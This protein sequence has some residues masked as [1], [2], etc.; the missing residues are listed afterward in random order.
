MIRERAWKN[1]S[2]TQVDV[3]GELEEEA[4]DKQEDEE[5]QDHDEHAEIEDVLNTRKMMKKKS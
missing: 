1:L 5:A 3:E 4:H 2:D